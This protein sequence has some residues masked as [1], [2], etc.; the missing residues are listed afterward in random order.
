M[1]DAGVAPKLR[2]LPRRD[3]FTLV[4][5]VFCVKTS[6]D[7]IRHRR[8]GCPDC[9]KGRP[10]RMG[11]A[12]GDTHCEGAASGR[13]PGLPG[14]VSDPGGE[15]DQPGDHVEPGEAAAV[16][17][18]SLASAASVNTDS[19]RSGSYPWISLTSRWVMKSRISSLT[20]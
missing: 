19:P 6:R 20:T 18:P 14:D 11:I 17:E 3:F 5:S 8:T 13:S 15:G 12:W 9:E 7:Q 1:L 16:C 2:A 4:A 10:S